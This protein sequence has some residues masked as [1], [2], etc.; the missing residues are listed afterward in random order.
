VQRWLARG[1]VLAGSWPAAAEAGR[2]LASLGAIVETSRAPDVALRQGDRTVTGRAT[3]IAEDWAAAGL[4]LMTGSPRRTVKAVRGA[5]AMLARAGA[6]AFELI[7]G[8]TVD[9]LDLLGQRARLLGLTGHGRTSA[10]GATRLLAAADGWWALNLARDLD[11]VPAL[12]EYAVDPDPEAAWTAV[13]AWA[14]SRTTHEILTRTRLLGLAASAL[15]ETPSPPAPWRVQRRPAKC[16]AARSRPLAV[17]LGALWAGPLA[18]HLLGLSGARVIHVESDTRPDPGRDSA[19]AFYQMLRAGDERRTMR[20]DRSGDLARLLAQADIVIEASRPRALRALGADTD[21]VLADGRARTWL[22]ITG[23]RD[24][25]R[26]AFGDDAAVAGGLVAYDD[27]GPIFAGDA[28]ADPL[29]G[30]LGA[31][32]VAAHLPHQETTVIDVALAEVSAY[33]AK[34]GSLTA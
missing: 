22:R 2:L 15:A 17:N 1:P 33:A 30:L 31:L 19:P 27:A 3:S 34:L 8:V 10:G 16:P 25:D 6:L 11:L 28:I 13:G 12:V 21:V 9:G 32:A 18:A 29:A 23:H 4:D 7:Q 5:P 24:G 20:F 14:Q 26:V